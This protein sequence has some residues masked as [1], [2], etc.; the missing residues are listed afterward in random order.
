[1]S[2]TA[3]PF[4]STEMDPQALAEATVQA[5]YPRDNASQALG[6]KILE[7]A[8]G[9]ARMSMLVRSDMLNGHATC[10]GGFIFAL[11]DSTFAF[12]CNSRNLNTV[13][14]GCSI[15]YVAPALRNDM[16]IAEAQERS[17]AGRTGVY[18]ITVSNQDGKT[19]AL[20]RGKSYRIRG[21]VISGLQAAQ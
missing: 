4:P 14:S 10:H 20:F 19:I 9:R 12:A 6:M 7:I 21:E 11:A 3:L 13:A 1:M 2:E 18:D 5:M 17:L 8:P 15:E 16:L